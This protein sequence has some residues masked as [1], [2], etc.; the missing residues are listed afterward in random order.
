MLR[1]LAERLWYPGLIR[2]VCYDPPF[3][4]RRRQSPFN[5]AA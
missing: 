2:M 3:I 5:A 1:R 4:D